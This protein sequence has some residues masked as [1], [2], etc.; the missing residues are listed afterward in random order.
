MLKKIISITVLA[1]SSMLITMLVSKKKEVEE[2]INFN[3]YS[4]ECGHEMC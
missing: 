4:S 3:N 2:P 1:I